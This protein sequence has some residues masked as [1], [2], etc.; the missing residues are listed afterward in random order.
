MPEPPTYLA[1]LNPHP[2]DEF[3]EFDEGP[4]IYTVH[5]EQGYTS[6]TTWNHHHFPK[7]DS[8]A[9]ISKM[10][11][12]KNMNDSSYKYFGMTREQIKDMW[13]KKR[14]ASATAGTK[15]HYDISFKS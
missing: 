7:F 1:K 15:L 6:V 3:I 14:D 2:R 12:S 8:D 13:D 4:H 9:I 11:K 5:G 10:L